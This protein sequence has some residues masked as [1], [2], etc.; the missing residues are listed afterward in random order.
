MFMVVITLMI[1]VTA[2]HNQQQALEDKQ[3]DVEHT[4]QQTELDNNALREDII[5][6][7]RQSTLIKKAKTFGMTRDQKKIKYV[8]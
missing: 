4:I 2:S 8:N 5:N 7:T 3:R 6:R 1:L